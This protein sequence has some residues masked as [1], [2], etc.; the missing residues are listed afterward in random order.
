LNS[1]QSILQNPLRS[2]A[3]MMRRPSAAIKIFFSHFAVHFPALAHNE[4]RSSKKPP[5]KPLRQKK[6]RRLAA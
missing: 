2:D 5:K 6:P 4:E 3:A 1:A